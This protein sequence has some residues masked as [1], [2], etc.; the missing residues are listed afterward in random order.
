MDSGKVGGKKAGDSPL[1]IQK[2]QALNELLFL[3]YKLR[4]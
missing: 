4:Y 1:L 3:K 2:G